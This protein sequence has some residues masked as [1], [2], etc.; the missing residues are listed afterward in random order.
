M[1][2]TANSQ[3]VVFRHDHDVLV[4]MIVTDSMLSGKPL[5]E[6]EQTIQDHL[7]E[8]MRGVVVDC[9]RLSKNVSSQ[10]L[11]ALARLR[12]ECM[13]QG[14]TVCLCGV[15]GHLREAIRVCCFDQLIPIYAS[16]K[17][18][19]AAL[20][21]FSEWEKVSM[22]SVAQHEASRRAK[23]EPASWLT[24]LATDPRA[25]IISLAVGICTVLV[26]VAGVWF[27]ASGPA[28]GQNPLLA[29]WKNA[30]SVPLSGKLNYVSRGVELAD[31]GGAIVAWPVAFVPKKKYECTS[32][33]LFANES[34]AVAPTPTGPFVARADASGKFR[35]EIRVL[36]AATCDY[37]VLAISNSASGPTSITPSDEA[38]L[39]LYFV[40]PGQLV[41]GR[42]YVLRRCE[43]QAGQS[44]E[45]DCLLREDQIQSA[46]TTSPL[47]NGMRSTAS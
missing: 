43:I 24:K 37:Y 32:A 12:I 14:Q 6:F 35:T 11:G 2:I 42:R 3:S 36:P 18:A 44:Q 40:D 45:I 39:S 46:R 27:F 20:G 29:R 30:D 34:G 16:Q 19:I 8:A 33:H 38:I 25:M 31:P 23:H 21:D 47:D 4:A 5:F 15:H 41:G 17:E 28:T 10:F 26:A 13:Q 7:A 1:T 22:A 9:S